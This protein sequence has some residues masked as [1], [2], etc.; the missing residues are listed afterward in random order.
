MLWATRAA[1]PHFAAQYP[2]CKAKML[3][4]LFMLVVAVLAAM[5]RAELHV[6][7]DKNFDARWV[8]R[9]GGWP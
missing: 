7:D 2:E 5:T 9:T 6:L 8:A 3:S 4:K 1:P